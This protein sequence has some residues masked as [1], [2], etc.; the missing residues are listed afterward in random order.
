MAAQA[1]VTEASREGMKDKAAGT[2]RCLAKEAVPEVGIAAEEDAVPGIRRDGAGRGMMA[3]RF[4]EDAA[5][6]GAVVLACGKPARAE[7]IFGYAMLAEAG[8]GE[9]SAEKAMLR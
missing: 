9:F 7:A 8:T 6:K 5:D 4:R 2:L 3:R 1:E